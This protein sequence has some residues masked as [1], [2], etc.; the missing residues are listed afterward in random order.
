MCYQER[1]MFLD[2]E[3]T[4]NV[5]CVALNVNTNWRCVRGSVVILWLEEMTARSQLSYSKST[6]VSG[7]A[8]RSLA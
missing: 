6:S 5:F 8:Q 7:K 3:D 1:N 4:H 2:L